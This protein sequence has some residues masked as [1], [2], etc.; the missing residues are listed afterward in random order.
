MTYKTKTDS[1]CRRNALT[2][3]APQR[4]MGGVPVVALSQRWLSPAIPQHFSRVAIEVQPKGVKNMDWGLIESRWLEY[5]AAA[6]RRWDKL[7][8][9]QLSGTRGNRVYLLKRVQEAYGLTPEQA[10]R[11]I[12]DWQDSQIDRLAPAANGP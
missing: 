5:K 11:E 3:A 4:N 10:E 9:A 8:E 12:A 2:Q 7:S 6:K 1:T